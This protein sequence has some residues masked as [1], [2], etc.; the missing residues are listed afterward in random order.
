MTANVKKKY[1]KKQ[2]EVPIA[3]WVEDSMAIMVL[4]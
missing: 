3:Y 4:M 2:G 1:N